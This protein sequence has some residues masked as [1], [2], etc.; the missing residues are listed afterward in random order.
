MI[1]SSL[2]MHACLV[3]PLTS[4]P[5]LEDLVPDHEEGDAEPGG[6]EDGQVQRHA[7]AVIDAEGQVLKYYHIY[8]G[9]NCG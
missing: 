7:V 1:E 5:V 8:D 4:G 2:W 6:H 9:R 3:R